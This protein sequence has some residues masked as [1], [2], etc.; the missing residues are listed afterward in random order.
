MSHR[1]LVRVQ[2][3]IVRAVGFL[4]EG[5][6][7]RSDPIEQRLQLLIGRRWQGLKVKGLCLGRGNKQPIGYDQVP[8]RIDVY[9]STVLL[10]HQNGTW[11]AVAYSQASAAQADP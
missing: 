6:R 1:L 10:Y 3:D 2:V 5:N 4:I 11:A 7:T 8:V 9:R